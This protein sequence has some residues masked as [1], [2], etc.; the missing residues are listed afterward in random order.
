MSDL[1]TRLKNYV[2]CIG[3]CCENGDLIEEAVDRIKAL[4]AVAD[5]AVPVYTISKR[6]H[7]AWN[8]LRNYL[9]AAG[10]NGEGE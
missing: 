1:L 7:I 2:F 9:Q 5:A 4:E 6:E 8:R 10:Y 3:P